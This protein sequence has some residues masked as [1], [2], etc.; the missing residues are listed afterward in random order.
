MRF[1]KQL[2]TYCNLPISLTALCIL[3]AQVILCTQLL[4]TAHV[5]HATTIY[6][7]T[8][9]PIKTLFPKATRIDNKQNGLPVYPV[10]QLDQLL[11]YAWLSNEINNLPGFSGRPISLL[12][13]LKADGVFSKVIVIEHHEPVFLHGLGNEA[14]DQFVDQYTGHSITEQV[15]I[16]SAQKSK[17]STNSAGAV[18]FD[19]VTKAT[20]SVMIVNDVVLATA[21]QVA[22]DKLDGFT[23]PAQSAL[24]NKS[25]ETMD[26][27]T[28]L[29]TGLVHKWH[30]SSEVVFTKLGR[31]YADYSHLFNSDGN[32]AD[33][34]DTF[35]DLYYAYLNA[36]DIGQNLLGEETYKK[37]MANLPP[38]DHLLWIGSNGLYP[39]IP[40]DFM[41]GTVPSRISLHQGGLN[42]EIKDTNA[43]DDEKTLT[44]ANAPAI[45]ESSIFRI[46]GISNFNLG[47]VVDIGLNINLPRNHLS[48]DSLSLTDHYQLPDSEWIAV[49]VEQQ[50][51]TPLWIRIWQDRI[52]QI[53]ILLTSLVILTV[54]FIKQEEFSRYAVRFHQFRWGYLWFTLLFTGYYAQ[55]QL[56]VV[57]IFTLLH[58]IRDGFNIS[59]FLL[60]P[61]I[62]ILWVFTFVSLFIWG[63]GLFCGWLCP[64]G[65]LQEMASWCGKKLGIKQVRI[66][67][68]LHRKL[69]YLKYPLLLGLI[70]VSFYELTLAERLAEV[71]P[72][73]TSIT[74][75][76]DRHWP[77]VLYAIALL[78]GGMFI[79]KF[80]CRYACPLGAGLA[81]IG[82]LRRFEWL[83]RIP[84]C[85]SPCQTC[86]HRC[87]IKAIKRDGDIDYN[88]CVQC[89]ECIVILN[90]EDQCADTLLK[91]KKDNKIAALNT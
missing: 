9:L 91:R 89:L 42:T 64:F 87:E 34:K 5:A 15:I 72:F 83:K 20:I 14:L 49:I 63:R 37:L 46:K 22:R 29:S 43:S 4:F 17:S 31:K 21:L 40:D 78:A 73:K 25:T 79:H 74:L 35:I 69:I 61:V 12:I 26:W 13:G 2:Q 48:T 59:I 65:A 6:D 23:L 10:Y 36:P 18:F 24:R 77:F 62:F 19:G 16:S 50:A 28:L 44:I 67:D 81:I 84:F 85:G 51:N 56:S 57:N 68:P 3:V 39:H 33:N 86:H 88:E 32:L 53:L 70:G 41:P 52:P 11:G 27:S 38:G 1:F 82:A 60:D 8:T 47:G 90:S 76:F 71:E 7:K 80:Y 66:P 55:G 58:S 75:V 30:V 45:A 54:V